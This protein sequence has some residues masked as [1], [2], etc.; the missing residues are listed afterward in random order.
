MISWKG[1][2]MKLKKGL[3]KVVISINKDID[4][5]ESKRVSLAAQRDT[6]IAGAGLE[7]GI[8]LK[9][10]EFSFKEMGFTKLKEEK[11]EKKNEQVEHNKWREYQPSLGSYV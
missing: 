2:D 6:L 3:A 8:D 9:K 10:Y 11:Q 1:K 7:K 4:I 5:L